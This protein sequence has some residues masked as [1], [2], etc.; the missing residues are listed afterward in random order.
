MRHWPRD[1]SCL[2]RKSLRANTRGKDVSGLA[3]RNDRM[4]SKRE[5]SKELPRR[6]S[7]I[8]M[9][10][11]TSLGSHTVAARFLRRLFRFHLAPPIP[12]RTDDVCAVVFSS[13][14]PPFFP[15]SRA[16]EGEKLHM[17]KRIREKASDISRLSYGFLCSSRGTFMFLISVLIFF[18]SLFFLTPSCRAQEDLYNIS[19]KSSTQNRVAYIIQV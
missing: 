15:L 14:L 3:T 13:L 18:K 19:F 17:Y 4:C 2:V 12:H 6:L 11:T 7:R 16:S 1:Q 5:A 10:I 9:E 8:T